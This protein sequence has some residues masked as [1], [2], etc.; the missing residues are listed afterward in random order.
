LPDV[1]VSEIAALT[2]CARN[3]TVEIFPH[4]KIPCGPLC[5]REEMTARSLQGASMMK[6]TIIFIVE[7]IINFFD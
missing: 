1:A 4:L 3:D 5:Q 6:I 7:V 2:T